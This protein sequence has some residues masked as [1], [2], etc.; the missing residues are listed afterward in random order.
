MNGSISIQI[1]TEQGLVQGYTFH[2]LYNE[3]ILK[4][5]IDFFPEFV[6]ESLTIKFVKSLI[7]LKLINI[8]RHFSPE[9]NSVW[10]LCSASAGILRS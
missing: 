8:F 10:M 5:S 4:I 2:K 3:S 9:V 7:I 1:L 6:I